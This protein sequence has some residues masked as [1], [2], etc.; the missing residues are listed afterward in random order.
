[1]LKK[2]FLVIVISFFLLNNVF[3]D[4]IT[5]KNNSEIEQFDFANGLFSRAMY[6]MAIDAYNDF[7]LKYPNSKFLNESFYRIAESY[8]FDKKYKESLKHFEEFI[9]KFPNSKEKFKAQL[10]VGQIYNIMGDHKKS[11]EIFNDFISKN[12]LEKDFKIE[13]EYYLIDTYFREKNFLVAKERFEKFLDKYKESEYILFGYISLADCCKELK[14]YFKAIEYYKKAVSFCE[15]NQRLKVQIFFRIAEIYYI[16]KDFN[17]AKIFYNK[18]IDI[19]EDN[20]VLDKAII[21]LLSVFYEQKEYNEIYN[22]FDELFSK[23]ESNDTKS[24][25]LYICGS[26]YVN[27]NNF[28][29]AKE[30][31][32]KSYEIYGNTKFGK[33]SKIRYSW[34]L[35]KTGE[36]QDGLFLLN[37]YTEEEKESLDEVLYMKAKMFSGLNKEKEAIVCY[38]KI[39]SDYE[40]SIFYKEALYELGWLYYNS[41]EMVVAFDMYKKFI[42]SYKDDTRS[43]SLVLKLAQENRKLKKYKESEKYYKKFLLLFP[44]NKLKENVLYQIGSMYFEIKDYD[45]AIEFFSKFIE[46]FPKSEII[47]NARYWVAVSYQSQEK[48]DNAIDIYNKMKLNKLDQL[49]PRVLEA[50]A[51]CFFQKKDYKN[52][53]EIYFYIIKNL[54]TYNL[55]KGVFIWVADYFLRNNENNKSIEILNLYKDTAKDKEIL[56]SIYYMLGENFLAIEKIDDSIRFLQKAINLRIESSYLG[57]TYL[58]LARAYYK[59]N[60]LKKALDFLEEILK[61][62]TEGKISLMARFEIGNINYDLENYEEYAKQY[63]MVAVLFDDK[64]FCPKALFKAGLSFYN[65][66]EKQKSLDVFKELIQRYPNDVLKSKAEDQINRIKNENK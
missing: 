56:F 27:D 14:E 48:W 28:L 4:E 44:D 36:F 7:I 1:M 64:S 23:G 9:F 18:V 57:R 42:D 51:Y 39:L 5:N 22:N 38:E 26:A 63:M 54:S 2:T 17:N 37:Q 62:N 34:V 58:A 10:R 13:V 40:K 45:K 35:Y 33:R 47:E 12:K 19:K 49:Y 53:A 55:P 21:G 52:A 29:Q 66:G 25:I 31:Y 32:K 46:E 59:N 16:L 61:N 41:G 8:F 43:S 24:Q 50:K 11:R 6:D 15:D 3:S 20:S 65:F 30:F 60:K